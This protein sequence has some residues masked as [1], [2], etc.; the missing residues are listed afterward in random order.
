M[1]TLLSRADVKVRAWERDID[2]EFAERIVELMESCSEL[3][4]RKIMPD[5]RL[6]AV[7]HGPCE[8]DLPFSRFSHEV[9]KIDGIHISIINVQSRLDIDNATITDF[10]RVLL[11]LRKSKP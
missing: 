7:F 11:S 5:D 8:A 3:P 9:C 10:V 2:V 6:A 4:L 1:K